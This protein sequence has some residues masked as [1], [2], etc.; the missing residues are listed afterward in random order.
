MVLVSARA[1]A[2]GTVNTVRLILI[3]VVGLALALHPIHVQVPPHGHVMLILMMMV[4]FVYSVVQAHA[5]TISMYRIDHD[6]I[7]PSA[8]NPIWSFIDSFDPIWF[9]NFRLP[10][11]GTPT[12][13]C[14][15]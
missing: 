9:D 13:A 3:L 4:F 12:S 2:P 6:L 14:S 5:A 1:H 15:I 11:I 10:C 8:T 7:W